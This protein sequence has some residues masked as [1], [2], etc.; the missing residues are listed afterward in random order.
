VSRLPLGP[1][2]HTFDHDAPIDDTNWHRLGM[3]LQD[4]RTGQ[5][6]QFVHIDL[7]RFLMPDDLSL[8]VTKALRKADRI[9]LVATHAA[10]DAAS[11]LPV[12]FVD[13][14]DYAARMLESRFDVTT[15]VHDE[16]TI[17]TVK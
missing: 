14:V 13:D 10:P 6:S 15:T 5:F 7:W 12:P 16:A 1:G 9:V 2:S 3:M 4:F 17:L 11:L 8:L